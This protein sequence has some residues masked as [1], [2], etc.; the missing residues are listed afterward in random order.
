MGTTARAV[1]CTETK[2]ATTGRFRVRGYSLTRK[3]SRSSHIP[4]SVPRVLGTRFGVALSRDRPPLDSGCKLMKGSQLPGP[5]TMVLANAPRGMARTMPSGSRGAGMTRC[6][7]KLFPRSILLY[8]LSEELLHTLADRAMQL[9]ILQ[10][11]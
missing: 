7:C 6:T 1:G 4:I 10:E 5:L 11:V 3:P 9:K 8:G 2:F